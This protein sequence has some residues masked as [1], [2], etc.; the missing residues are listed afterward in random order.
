MQPS[1]TLVRRTSIA[2]E[3]V[4]VGS[5]GSYRTYRTQNVNHSVVVG[6]DQFHFQDVRF[7]PV[8]HVNTV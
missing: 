8:R 1:S 3:R 2:S 5:G 4:C 6:D 7:P